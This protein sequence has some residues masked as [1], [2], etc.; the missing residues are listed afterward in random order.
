LAF[1]LLAIQGI[2]SDD[3]TALDFL[4]GDF[5]DHGA[6]VTS[7]PSSGGG[8][9]CP[10]PGD[11]GAP[12]AGGAADDA[13][14]DAG[15]AGDLGYPGSDPTKAPPGTEWRGQPGSTPGS[16]EGSYYNPSTGESFRPDLNHP[17]PIGP[18]W[19]YRAPDGTWYRIM[20]DG[21]VIPK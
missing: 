16:P 14:G 1:D 8:G 6:T 21:T 20:P 15:D 7:A 19:D 4:L 18:H 13:G 5:V 9:S 12:G 11:D 17:D 2:V 3:W 10:P